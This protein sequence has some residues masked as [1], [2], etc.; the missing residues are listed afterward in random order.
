MQVQNIL[1]F[2]SRSNFRNLVT[3]PFQTAQRIAG[4]AIG[5]VASDLAQSRLER[6][7]AETERAR[8]RIAQIYSYTIS[9]TRTL[10]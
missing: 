7:A 1:D 5:E 10:P 9:W 6:S 8:V 3:V 4:F 2:N